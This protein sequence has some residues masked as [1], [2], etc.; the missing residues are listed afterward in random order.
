MI[1]NFFICIDY[2]FEFGLL[3]IGIKGCCR[4]IV[5]GSGYETSGGFVL[6]RGIVVFW[7]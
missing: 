1:G 2:L 7:L 6:V 5:V 4:L 3:G